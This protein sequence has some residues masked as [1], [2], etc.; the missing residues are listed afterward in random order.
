MLCHRS[1]FSVEQ[2]WPPSPAR[3]PGTMEAAKARLAASSCTGPSP[4]KMPQRTGV[5]WRPSREWQAQPSPG[6]KRGH[7]H[8]T[9]QTMRPT[10]ELA[11]VS[12]PLKRC[13]QQSPGDVSKPFKRWRPVAGNM[14]AGTRYGQTVRSASGM[15]VTVTKRLKRYSRLSL[16]DRQ[17]TVQT[18]RGGSTDGQT[19]AR[20]RGSALTVTK[21]AKRCG[22]ETVQRVRCADPPRGARA[23]VDTGPEMLQ[24]I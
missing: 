18:V 10:G 21:R 22:Q 15:M 1:I 4:A 7:R 2:N 8:E 20:N 17:Q 19:G 23:T 6:D 9:D 5:K 13:R 14:D 11:T 24:T 3:Q 16:G 12:K